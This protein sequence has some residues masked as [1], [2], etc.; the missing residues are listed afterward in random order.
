M[1]V[2]SRSF[3]LSAKRSADASLALI[4]LVV[5]SPI[6]IAIAVMV[7]LKLGTPVLFTQ[8]RPGKDA[9]P[10]HLYKF[11][12]M[13]DGRDSQGNLLPDAERLVPF[14]KFL[15]ASSL[16]E[17]PELWNIL[18]GDMSIVGPR[19]LLMDYVPLYN[20]EQ[21]RRMCFRPGLTGLAQIS[22]RNLLSWNEK[23]ALDTRYVDEWTP[24][25]DA[26]IIMRTIFAVVLQRG[27][28]AEGDATMPRFTGG[29][30][31]AD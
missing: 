2:T 28:S 24:A 27:I 29:G 7:R 3:W 12:T 8:L 30:P 14:G 31:G 23:F 18:R 1:K 5:L 16:D 11:R 13:T 17:L 15:R 10:F 9:R 25:L 21:R 4:G 19:P 26:Q 20:A 6:L 22:G